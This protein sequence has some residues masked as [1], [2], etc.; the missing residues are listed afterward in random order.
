MGLQF[1]LRSFLVLL[2][3]H[4]RSMKKKLS[5]KW[6]QECLEVGSPTTTPPWLSAGFPPSEQGEKKKVVALD[7]PVNYLPFIQT[8]NSL[9]RKGRALSLS[10]EAQRYLS[11]LFIFCFN[12]HQLSFSMRERIFRLQYLWLNYCDGVFLQS[13]KNNHKKDLKRQ[14][15]Y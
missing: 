2:L 3:S 4:L 8:P 9:T 10:K 6:V 13:Y 11:W 7:V 15:L 14:L 12:R 1:A 5:S